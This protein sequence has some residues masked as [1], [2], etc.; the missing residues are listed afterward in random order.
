ME[1][2]SRYCGKTK[3]KQPNL[4]GSSKTVKELRTLELTICDAHTLP[5]SKL[6]HPYCIV[7]LNDAKTCRTKPQEG[8]SPVWSEDFK[9]K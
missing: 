7:S 8:P 3:K 4:S 5:Q 6:S 1:S 2:I 9:F